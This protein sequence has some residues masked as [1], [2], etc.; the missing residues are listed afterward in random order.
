M[1]EKSSP[2]FAR[3]LLARFMLREEFH[4]KLGDLEE[5]FTMELKESGP[6]RA[7]LWYWGQVIVSIPF[8]I[9]S[10]I[11]GEG[12]MIKNYLKSTLRNIL[13]YKGYSF[14]NIFGLAT[15]FAC[16]ILI[17]LWV[18]QE[19]SYD[20]FQKN[21]ERL[22]RIT[23]ERNGHTFSSN[24]WALIPILKE[25]Y[26]EI[27]AGS[28]FPY[29]RLIAKY[30][31][32]DLYADCRMVSNE[33]FEMFTYKFLY[34]TAES[35]LPNLNSVVLTERMA[36][37]LFG[38]KNPLGTTL[39]FDNNIEFQVT[40]VIE[41]PPSNSHL[42]FDA[43]LQPN[44]ITGEK[45]LT[46]WS[47]DGPGYVM[48]KKNVNVDEVR[49]KIR[50]T[51]NDFDRRNINKWYV[52]L[53]PL[54]EINLYALSGTDPILYVYIFS[55]IAIIVLLI[56]CINFVNLSTARSTRRA[57]EVGLRKVIGA[58][59]K[60]LI[61]QFMGEAVL[62]TVISLIFAVFIAYLL[63]PYFNEIAA[64]DLSLNFMENWKLTAGLIII[65]LITGLLSGLYPS[66]LISSFLPVHLFKNLT[67]SGSGNRLRKLL[68][69]VQFVATITLIISTMVISNQIDYIRNSNLGFERE[70]IIVIPT[71]KQLRVKYNTIKER[72]LNESSITNV[73]AASQAPL[74]V[75][76]CNPVYWEGRSSENYEI[77]NFVCLD[78]DY[79]ETFEMEMKY[80]RSFSRDYASDSISYII[81]EA[82]LK[83]TGYENPIGK[84]FSM[85]TDEASIVGV[86]KD[87]HGTS[88]H[89]E[90]SPI[91]FM[92]YQ[93]L[94]YL[95]MFIK[96]N[97]QN[98][99][100]TI[101]KIQ[102]VIKTTVPEFK[103]EYSFMD[104]DFNEQ[105]KSEM[106]IANLFESFSTLAILI[107]CLGLVG[108]VSYMTEKRT[109]EIAIRKVV[110]ASHSVILSLISKEFVLLSLFA[111]II[112][113]PIAYYFMN[114]WTTSFAYFES[115]SLWTFLLAG[116]IVLLQTLLTISYQALR[117]AAAK[118]VDALKA[119]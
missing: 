103:F 116:L 113:W 69:V 33:F 9:K 104:E 1:I 11:Y 61:K 18:Q 111:N 76:A 5:V 117:A 79:F 24:P 38:S 59:R 105:Y 35:S 60:Q 97:P 58:D 19:I 14:I 101:E 98:L 62:L 15:G 7:H 10:T 48:L 3:W 107:S 21:C 42:R 109:K 67:N 75:S 70:H 49:G 83:L 78:Y 72:L 32:K 95:K 12:I 39:L 73:S 29:R 68:I 46:T 81:N 43:I 106:R 115:L 25:N 41:N 74:N 47:M 64:R 85:W 80:G 119:E 50:N 87:F 30:G 99:S 93:N 51:I 57:K 37:K 4:E 23:I 108:M 63:L 36:T 91:V 8:L 118:P 66:L 82:A 100:A 16:C 84:M 34:G 65:A 110:G 90:I 77:M 112:A 26:P 114:A 92:L 45:R 88:L 31:E 96:V 56:A 13:K 22:Y 86:V 71:N 53:Q 44:L 55:S 102:S 27:E 52:G 89:N 54:R 20:D 2:G 94:P 6:V 17:M 28:S 40:G